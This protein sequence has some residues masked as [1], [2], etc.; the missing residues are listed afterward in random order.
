MSMKKQL[1]NHK[2]NTPERLSSSR[3]LLKTTVSEFLDTADTSPLVLLTTE[4]TLDLI[5]L[6]QQGRATSENSLFNA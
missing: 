5:A 2:V 3:I 6:P 4:E 1:I